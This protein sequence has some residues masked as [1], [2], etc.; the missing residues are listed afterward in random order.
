MV[1]HRKGV[2]QRKR[3][4]NKRGEAGPAREE[5]QADEKLQRARELLASFEENGGSILSQVQCDQEAAEQAQAI[6]LCFEQHKYFGSGV[7]SGST[8]MGVVSGIYQHAHISCLHIEHDDDKVCCRACNWPQPLKQQQRAK[9]RSRG[10][11]RQPGYHS[12]PFAKQFG[13]NVLSHEVG[14]GTSRMIKIVGEGV[15]PKATI[16]LNMVW[17]Q[18]CGIK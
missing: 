14:I 10:K 4:A 6:R 11:N 16:G 2:N 9:P 3:Q 7:S 12:Q 8:A 15:A 5:E 1:K 18:W 17:N 13:C